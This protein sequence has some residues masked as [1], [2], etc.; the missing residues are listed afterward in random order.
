MVEMPA[1]N[2]RSIL[3][4]AVLLMLGAALVLAGW[5]ALAPQEASACSVCGRPAHLAARVIGEAD[6]QSLTFCCAACALRAESQ[7][8]RP[9]R[10]TQVS[11]YLTGEPLAPE[12]ATAV[13][14]SEINVCMR[15]H[16]PA[17][18]R[19]GGHEL[20]FDRCAPSVL[21]F[22]TQAAAEQFRS[23]YGGEV[24][25]FTELEGTLP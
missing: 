14:G 19:E 15:D 8:D 4:F 3:P 10:V 11:N 1:P 13:V 24:R 25:P 9:I 2:P 16:R 7:Q 5:W 17:D 12:Q 6:G 23:Q 20:H 22:P 18:P 21:A